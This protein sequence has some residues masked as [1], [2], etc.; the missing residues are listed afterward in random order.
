MTTSSH[1]FSCGQAKPE[2]L[3]LIR[4]VRFERCRNFVRK[5]TFGHYRWQKTNF[6]VKR[7]HGPPEESAVRF[8]AVRRTTVVS[9]AQSQARGEECALVRIDERTQTAF[10]ALAISEGRL[11]P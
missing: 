1:L 4:T 3:A 8:H 2:D 9:A 11:A 5:D 6:F 10:K 7:D